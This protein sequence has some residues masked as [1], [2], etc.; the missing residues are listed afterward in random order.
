VEASPK[1]N[2]SRQRLSIH[3][4]E[5]AAIPLLI[6]RQHALSLIVDF[7]CSWDHQQT[8]LMVQ[9][10]SFRV[11]PLGKGQPLFRYEFESDMRTAHL[12]SAHLHVHAHRD[13]FL[14]A[15]IRGQKGRPKKRAKAV[16]GET[17]TSVPRLSD[18]HFPLGGARM[19]PCLEDVLEMLHCEFGVD[20]ERGAQTVLDEGRARWRRRQI[21]AAVRDAPEEAVRVLRE[22]GYP[23][24]DHPDGPQP[25]RLDKLTST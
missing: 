7:D 1:R 9:R 24:E 23:I 17:K 25:D 16:I 14:Y 11:E 18:I 5:S 10:A 22:L 13:E 15:M 2:A 6:D 20:L 12:P 3:T 19:R 8:Y 21:G 4:K